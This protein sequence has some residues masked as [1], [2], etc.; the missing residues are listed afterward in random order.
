MFVCVRFFHGSHD[1]TFKAEPLHY[2]SPSL[3]MCCAQNE[4]PFHGNKV[5]GAGVGYPGFDPLGG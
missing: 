1:M 4:D 2:P 5:S 3:C